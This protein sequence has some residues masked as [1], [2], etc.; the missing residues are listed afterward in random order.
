MFVGNEDSGVEATCR[1]WV[2]A[3]ITEDRVGCNSEGVEGVHN[4]SEREQHGEQKN[5]G[6]R[7]H[8]V[9]WRSIQTRKQCAGEV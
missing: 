3:W 1:V 7:E 4:T 2:G 8:N 6:E 5:T 9:Y